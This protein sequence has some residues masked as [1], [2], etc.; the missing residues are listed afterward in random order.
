[1]IT[2]DQLDKIWFELAEKEPV[3]LFNFGRAVAAFVLAQQWQS[4]ESAPKDGSPIVVWPPTW[5]GISSCA[6][7]NE[8]KYAKNPKPYWSRVDDGG[9]VMASRGNPPTHWM[10]LP[11]APTS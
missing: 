2:D 5:T 1:M 8:D 11:A 7:W 6:R 10:P 4:I 3:T 9:R